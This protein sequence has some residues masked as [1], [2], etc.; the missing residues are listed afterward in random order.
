MSHFC[1]FPEL[2]TCVECSASFDEEGGGCV[3]MLAWIQ[4]GWGRWLRAVCY[5]LH[6]HVSWP[7]HFYWD[8]LNTKLPSCLVT[9]I[10]WRTVYTEFPSGKAG[11]R[12]IFPFF[13]LCL[14]SKSKERWLLWTLAHSQTKRNVFIV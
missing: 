4:E 9:I 13:Y 11:I 2:Q 10:S 6:P 1:I 14:F 7:G 12:N 8:S 3:S 5:A